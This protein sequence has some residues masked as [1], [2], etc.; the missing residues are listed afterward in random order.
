MKRYA[1][2]AM[3]LAVFGA[4]V[5]AQPGPSP[6]LPPPGLNTPLPPILVL[7]PGPPPSN[8][9]YAPPT[10]PAGPAIPFYKSGNV[11]VGADGYYPYDTG[12]YL[13]ADTQVARYG[14]YF[15]MAYPPPSS[16][17]LD[18]GTTPAFPTLP[19]LFHGRG[20]CRQR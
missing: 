17:H 16:Y 18:P 11:L 20:H 12:L 14:G 7:P 15:T 3:L 1:I 13:L 8:V 6:P 9:R 2:A 5:S 4:S 10:I 19:Q